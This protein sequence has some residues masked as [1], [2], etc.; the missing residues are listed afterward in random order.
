VVLRSKRRRRVLL[1]NEKAANEGES[2]KGVIDIFET[3]HSTSLGT[4]EAYR[5]LSTTW[6]SLG[7]IGIDYVI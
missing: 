6:P 3:Y 2:M 1:G 7:G 4:E 5:I